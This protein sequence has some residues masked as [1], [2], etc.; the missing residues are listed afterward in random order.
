M[1]EMGIV[2]SI[3]EI[4]EQQAKLYHAKRVVKVNLEFGALTAVMPS[5]VEFAFTV[6]SKDG[7]AEG[8]QLD[9][10][11]IPLK[12]HCLDCGRDAILDEYRPFCP[13]CSSAA[14][15]IVQGRDEMRI[16]SLEIEDT[17]E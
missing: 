5:A 14:L 3:I 15:Q 12:V 6:L 4:I 1:H 7:I 10:K 11:I 8:A 9:I 17:D 16:A 13:A 2:Q